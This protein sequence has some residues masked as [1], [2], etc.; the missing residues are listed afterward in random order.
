MPHSPQI[1]GVVFEKPGLGTSAVARWASFVS[2]TL[3]L[4]SQPQSEDVAGRVA[5]CS[6][7]VVKNSFITDPRITIMSGVYAVCEISRVAKRLH[8][9]VPRSQLRAFNTCSRNV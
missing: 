3:S 2:I 4:V 6:V 5:Y 7:L 1:C 9:A 8:D